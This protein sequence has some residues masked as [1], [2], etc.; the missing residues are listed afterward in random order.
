MYL[1]FTYFY[2]Q[3]SKTMK[4]KF[5][6][7]AMLATVCSVAFPQLP[8]FRE[9]PL[10]V[11]VG[12]STPGAYVWLDQDFSYYGDFSVDNVACEARDIIRYPALSVEVGYRIADHG[13]FK[14]LSAVGYFGTDVAEYRKINYVTDETESTDVVF[15]ADVLAGMRFNMCDAGRFHLYAQLMLGVSLHGNSGLF[16]DKDQIM[17][18]PLD[19]LAIQGAMGVQVDVSR[20]SRLSVLTQIGFGTEYSLGGPIVP[21]LRVGMG[22]K[23]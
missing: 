3:N 7:T 23:F 6:L 10:D 22:Y 4:R 9:F 21:G 2:G 14:K 11:N 8:V 13:F 16:Q 18:A 20:D 12:I 19:H 5:I 15:L 1:Y 17:S